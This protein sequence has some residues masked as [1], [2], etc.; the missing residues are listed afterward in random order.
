MFDRISPV[1]LGARKRV[2]E[3]GKFA[4]VALTKR[5]FTHVLLVCFS[6]K[7]VQWRMIQVNPA[8][9]F[10]ISQRWTLW[11]VTMLLIPFLVVSDVSSWVYLENSDARHHASVP[12]LR[13]CVPLSTTT[14]C[15][16]PPHNELIH[17]VN[18]CPR[19]AVPLGFATQRDSQWPFHAV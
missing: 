17:T 11:H 9:L 2:D 18:Q 13:N 16:I 7:Y 3:F 4:I 10:A 15:N 1:C 14:S 8:I 19:R 12:P 6:R 5:G